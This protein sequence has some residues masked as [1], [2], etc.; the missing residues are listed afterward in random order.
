MRDTP[1]PRAVRVFQLLDTWVPAVLIAAVTLLIIAE[2]VGRWAGTPAIVWSVE[3]AAL[4]FTWAVFLGG[5]A[6]IRS[7]RAIKV[8]A[9][10]GALPRRAQRVCDVFA[11]LVTAAVAI[12]WA[13]LLVL[14]TREQGGLTTPVLGMPFWTRTVGAAIAFV[15]I[16]AYAV[17]RIVRGRSLVDVDMEA[18]LDREE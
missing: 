3:I 15:L 18:L 8:D 13:W 12:S 17:Y 5:A 11:D 6:A 4:L 10:V 9:L 14:L 2:T 7:G 16:T 1:R